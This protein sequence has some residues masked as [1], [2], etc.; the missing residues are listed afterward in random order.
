MIGGRLP[1][2][3]LGTR[4]LQTSALTSP[5]V[6]ASARSPMWPEA[7]PNSF[8]SHIASNALSRFLVTRLESNR[9]L[10]IAADRSLEQSTAA[11][12]RVPRVNFG[13]VLEV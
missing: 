1:D 7:R 11:R 2:K 9:E 10:F 6:A 12:N 4:R 5:S 8:C 13:Y 3:G